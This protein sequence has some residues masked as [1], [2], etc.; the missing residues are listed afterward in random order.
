MKNE[1][2]RR[3]N[4]GIG[5]TVIASLVIA[6]L[7]GV[8]IFGPEQARS[9]GAV[10]E[11]GDI[12][13]AFIGD[14]AS[15]A[16]AGGQL[17]P[18]QEA[19]LAFSGKGSVEQINVVV[20]DSV[21]AGDVLV[22]LDSDALERAV[23]RAEQNLAIQKANLA[24]LLAAPDAEDVA[25]AEASV[26]NAQAQLD[27]LLAGPSEKELA[28][29]QAALDSAQAQ[30]D[31]LLAGP[32]E[33]ELAQAQA[34]LDSALAGLATAQA[35]DALLDDQ[36][37]AAQND[38][39]SA[40]ISLDRARDAYNHLLWNSPDR[41]VAESWGPY[42]PQGVALTKA[43]IN[44]DWA[45]ANYAL[46]ELDV[47]DSALRSAEAQ[48]A[49]AR[50]NLAALTEEKTVQ[51]ASARAQVARA[52]KNLE[53]LTEDKTVQ[54]ASARSQLAQAEANLAQLLDGASDQ[55]ILMAEIA[56]EQARVQLGDA[57]TEL[58]D[59]VLV[60]PFDGLVTDVY[61]AIDEQVN[62][63]AV[64]LVNTDSM[65]VVLDVDEVDLDEIEVGQDVTVELEAW[66]DRLFQGRVASIA[67]RATNMGRIV[68]YEVRLD[69]D[70]DSVP[71]AGE[72]HI[73]T[74]MTADADLITSRRTDVLLVANKAITADRDA[75]AY[76]VY[77]VEGDDV[78]KV[79]VTIGLR[80]K[81]YTEIVNGL[82]EGDKLVIGYSELAAASAVMPVG[83]GNND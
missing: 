16:S 15:S 40:Q 26:A 30:L 75:G 68:T 2:K 32:S 31:D 35:R 64:E 12:V 70:W 67:P 49:Q 20:G 55:R 19:R 61:V 69:V 38:I 18:G 44:Y 58:D 57:Q 36:L 21:E 78:T 14:T 4:L 74:G 17:L 81:S 83:G 45:V 50:A 5:A 52:E 3:R 39:D 66:P 77:R 33:K 24:A 72:I 46:I 23:Q 51:I 48:V 63:P 53:A 62:G 56:V 41:M 82:R 13:T 11:T 8:W 10:P 71:D 79:E 9:A 34:A 47:N 37:V 28:Q 60:A 25:A 27:D 6:I 1:K 54:I 73:L 59:A 43:E 22:Q 29:A 65:Q 7:G 80:D 76:Y 42:S